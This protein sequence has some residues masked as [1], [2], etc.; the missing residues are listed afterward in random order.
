MVELSGKV[1][2]NTRDLVGDLIGAKN[3]GVTNLPHL[4]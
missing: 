3:V 2:E 1:S 4:K